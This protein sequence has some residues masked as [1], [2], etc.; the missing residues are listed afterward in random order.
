MANVSVETLEPC[1]KLVRFELDAA[2][3]EKV[4]AEVEK[5]YQKNAA[6][7]GF[8]K[9]KAPSAIVFK[10]FAK[11]IEDESKRRL[12][13]D[14]Y[15]K[16]I[17]ENNLNV[18]GYPDIEEVEFGRGKPLQFVA[19]IEIY[20]EFELPEY[21]ALPAKRETTTVTDAD[22]NRAVDSL[23]EQRAKFDKVDRAAQEGDIIVVNYT[24]TCDGTPIIELAP[25]AKGLSEQKGFWIE[26]RAGAFIPGFAEQLYGAKA[27]DKRTVTVDFPADFVQPALSG[28]KGVYEVEVTEVR[29]RVLPEL[30]EAFAKSWEAE[31]LEKLRDGVRRDLQ[32]KLNQKI[33]RSIRNQ[34]V[35]AMLGKVTI[36]LPES[37]VQK[38]T[39]NVV[40]DL[41]NENQRRGV[42]REIIDRE[43]DQI[44]AA[45]AQT[46]KDR[47]KVGFLFH[48]IAE[49][50]GI[51]ASKEEMN[52]RIVAMASAY[53]MP[54]DKF[55][56][57]LEKRDGFSEVYQ[58]IIHEKVLD[59]LHENAK[60][61]D[62]APGQAPE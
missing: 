41:V 5:D 15:G 21:R 57:E 47:V 24:G 37:V 33:K 13:S 9:G 48:K 28:K 16:A 55:V 14:A 29:V 6:L 35:G 32:N 12:V 40:Y 7:P 3:V 20:P 22:V 62:A 43:K 36:D 45:A 53:Q 23:R 8:R 50:E 31:S 54:V 58:Q 25:A 19:K 2:E 61:E 26:G 11:E 18:I 30:D 42:A 10:T 1:K 51:R 4:F 38:E 17:K 27:G 39:R 49:K 34:L 56:K 46:A 60:L 44:Y 52:A 59:F